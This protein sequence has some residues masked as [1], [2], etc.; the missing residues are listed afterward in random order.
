MPFVLKSTAEEDD[1][2][3]VQ[4]SISALECMNWLFIVGSVLCIVASKVWIAQDISG[5]LGD[6]LIFD[7]G[8]YI[9]IVG[10]LVFSI[11]KIRLMLNKNTSFAVNMRLYWIS[12]IVC[13]SYA[14]SCYHF[15]FEDGNER[16]EE[17]LIRRILSL[18]LHILHLFTLLL[19]V[20]AMYQFTNPKNVE[21]FEMTFSISMQ[22]NF[23]SSSG[24]KSHPSQ[25]I[26]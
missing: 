20:Y 12:V 8:P 1:E 6:K 3:E 11:V 10:V 19:V 2:E 14:I 15:S 24:A 16:E 26:S 25:S 23:D 5:Y 21:N 18:T 13:I 7:L 17:D 9:F 4:R 22:T